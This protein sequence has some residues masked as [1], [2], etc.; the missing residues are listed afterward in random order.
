MP[1]PAA[2]RALRT[3][4]VLLGLAALG[5]GSYV[6]LRGLADD[7]CELALAAAARQLAAGDV[8][9]ARSQAVLALG[10]CEGDGRARARELQAAADKAEAAQAVCDRT[11]RNAGSSLAQ[12]KLRSA[13]T[14][15]DG[16]DARCAQANT[17]TQLRERLDQAA[18]AA[19]ASA[20]SARK[21]LA[22][23]NLSGAQAALDQLQAQNREHPD[24]A[25]LRKELGTAQQQAAAP[26]PAPIAPSFP[27]PVPAPAP[28]AVLQQGS[29]Q[30][31]QVQ[32]LLRAAENALTRSRFEDARKYVDSVRRIDPANAQATALL[33]R[34]RGNEQQMLERMRRNEQ[35]ML[36]RDT[37]IR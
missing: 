16:L 10:S 37:V 11:L 23:A 1:P 13:R 32:G 21:Q 4:W 7:P 8:A 26:A 12:A 33:E 15:L 31:E 14:A 9:G 2:H 29:A 3:P 35:R 24:L 6:V 27:A 30:A 18:Q 28:P 36:E 5:L 25:A 20:D 22:L 17:A 34:I 19:D